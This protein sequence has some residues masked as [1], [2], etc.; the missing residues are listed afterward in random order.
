M[1]VGRSEEIQ[2]IIE[3]LQGPPWKM[4]LRFELLMLHDI[5]PCA[6]TYSHSVWADWVT[7]I[8]GGAKAEENHIAVMVKEW[9][10]PPGRE[11]WPCDPSD[12]INDE[13]WRSWRLTNAMYAAIVVSIWS[14]MEHFLKGLVRTCQKATG[15]HGKTPHE[16]P[17]IAEFFRKTLIIDLSTLGGYCKVNAI[18]ILNNSFKHNGG[19]Y[20]PSTEAHTQI[21]PELLQSWGILG[22][23]E[24]IDYAKLPIQHLVTACNTFCRDLLTKLEPELQRCGGRGR[25]G[26]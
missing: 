10:R 22:K 8:E 7:R 11:N 19:H 9:K 23:C 2:K 12:W 5:F 6:N 13:Y 24:E 21:S 18:R 25:V 1:A 26:G 16:F 17:K 14:D 3:E 20:N 15:M 4:E